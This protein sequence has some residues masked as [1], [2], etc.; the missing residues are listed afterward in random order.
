MP[1]DVACTAYELVQSL[2]AIVKISYSS[3]RE[4]KGKKI[5]HRIEVSYL[6][7]F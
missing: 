7:G 2:S 5:N 4:L 6:L 3:E 1:L